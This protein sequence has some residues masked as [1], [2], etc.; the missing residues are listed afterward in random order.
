MLE[1]YFHEQ[2]STSKPTLHH[3]CYKSHLI[4]GEPNAI[5]WEQFQTQWYYRGIFEKPKIAQYYFAR[6]EIPCPAYNRPMRQSTTIKSSNNATLLRTTTEIFSKYRKKTNSVLTLR[7]FRKTEKNP[8]NTSPDP[9]IEPE[10]PCPAVTLATTRPTRQAV[11][12]YLK[13]YMK[14][15]AV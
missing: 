1:A 6:P 4:G 7:N 15:R 14:T 12:L 10:T 8:S 11:N 2:H 5:Y 9:G 3:L 13:M